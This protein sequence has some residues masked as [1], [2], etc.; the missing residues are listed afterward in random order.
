MILST[1]SHSYTGF[2]IPIKLITFE[3]PKTTNH[4]KYKLNQFICSTKNPLNS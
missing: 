3:I 2:I 4:I 1:F